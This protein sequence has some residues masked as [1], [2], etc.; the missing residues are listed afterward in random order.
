MMCNRCSKEFKCTNKNS[1]K[2]NQCD[3]NSHIGRC[4]CAKCWT[5][6]MDEHIKGGVGY[7]FEIKAFIDCYTKKKLNIIKEIITEATV[8]SL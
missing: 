2:Y 6:S 1:E 4:I 7:E 3:I 5:R 8:H